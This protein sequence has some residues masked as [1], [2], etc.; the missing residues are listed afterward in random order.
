LYLLAITNYLSDRLQTIN[1]HNG[2]MS[3]PLRHIPRARLKMQASSALFAALSRFLNGGCTP[4]NN[5]AWLNK[6]RRSRADFNGPLAAGGVKSPCPHQYDDAA[7]YQ[8][9]ERFGRQLELGSDRQL[10]ALPPVL[11]VGQYRWPLSVPPGWQRFFAPW[12]SLVCAKA[13]S[14]PHYRLSCCKRLVG[15]AWLLLIG[16]CSSPRQ[17]C[18]SEA[19]ATIQSLR[20]AVFSLLDSGHPTRPY[21]TRLKNDGSSH[22]C[23][24]R[25]L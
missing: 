15:N 17:R 23:Y 5:H 24:G 22:L 12:R 4:K 18:K 9:A 1:F 8:F 14:W 2:S 10:S 7:A 19:K 16:I 11:L 20:T 21:P 13:S 3:I 6:W 25:G